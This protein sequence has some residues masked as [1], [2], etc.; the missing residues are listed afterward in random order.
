MESTTPGWPSAARMRRITVVVESELQ[1]IARSGCRINGRGRPTTLGSPW[2]TGSATGPPAATADT[3]SRTASIAARRTSWRYRLLFPAS[4][5]GNV[6]DAQT[7]PPSTSPVA[8]STVTPHS[9]ISSSIA[10]SS[11]DGPRSPR[12]PGCTIRQR[13]LLQTDSGMIDLSIGQRISSGV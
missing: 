5:V 11:E 8:S 13:C 12:G 1:S 2:S 3:A 10:Q 4:R 6:R 9:A 7:Q